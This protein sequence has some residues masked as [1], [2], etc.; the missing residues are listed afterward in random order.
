[1]E[2][3][4]ENGGRY[5]I[6]IFAFLLGAGLLDREVDT[7]LCTIASPWSSSSLSSHST[8]LINLLFEFTTK[9]LLVPSDFGTEEEQKSYIQLSLFLIQTTIQAPPYHTAPNNCL[10]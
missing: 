2:R 7:Y 5:G 9:T 1:M 4:S 3:L 8:L 10:G 6:A